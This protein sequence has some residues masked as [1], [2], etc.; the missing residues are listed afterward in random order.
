M[1]PPGGATHFGT[2]GSPIVD[3]SGLGDRFAGPNALY[4][5]RKPSV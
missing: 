5:L 1:M 2:A 3:P 4:G